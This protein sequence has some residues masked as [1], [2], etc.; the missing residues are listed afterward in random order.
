MTAEPNDPQPSAGD[1]VV[2]LVNQFLI[3][4]AAILVACLLAVS[5]HVA[6]APEAGGPAGTVRTD[7]SGDPGVR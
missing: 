1:E 3:R 6:T 2:R 4:I 5:G 7:G